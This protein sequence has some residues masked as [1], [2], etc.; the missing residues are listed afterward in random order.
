MFWTLWEQFGADP[1]LFQ[2]EARSINTWMT[3]SGVNELNWPAQ[4]PYMILWN[5]LEQRLRA[6][7]CQPTSACVLTDAHLEEW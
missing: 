1:F 3:E 6:R 4:S 7:P 5:K 2:P